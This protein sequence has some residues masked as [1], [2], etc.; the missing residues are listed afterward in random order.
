MLVN[1]RG[2]LNA[3]IR[4]EEDGPDIAALSGTLEADG[5]YSVNR[6]IYDRDLYKKNRA[7][8]LDDEEEFE[9][10]LIRTVLAATE[11]KE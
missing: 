7:A 11:E 4:L 6:Y 3:T 1:T 9:A 2:N 10:A 8:V 5:R